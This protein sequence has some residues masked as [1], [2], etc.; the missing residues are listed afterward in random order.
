MQWTSLRPGCPD[1]NVRHWN[2]LKQICQNTLIS[3]FATV[4]RTLQEGFRVWCCTLICWFSWCWVHRGRLVLC[5]FKVDL[6]FPLILRSSD[7]CCWSFFILLPSWRWQGDSHASAQ[8]LNKQ[9]CL[10]Q[11]SLQ[12]CA[13]WALVS[14]DRDNEWAEWRKRRRWGWVVSSKRWS[15]GVIYYFYSLLIR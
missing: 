13:K 5:C 1:L 8:S 4:L 14:F 15:C 6:P 11:L 2:S 10:I 3:D 9:V 12:G 7:I